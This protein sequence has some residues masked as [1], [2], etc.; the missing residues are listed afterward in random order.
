LYIYPS[1]VSTG[2]TRTESISGGEGVVV[3]ENTKTINVGD[4]TPRRAATAERHME[5]QRRIAEI[6]QLLA[7]DKART[8]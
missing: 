7:A 5:L 4:S 8:K 6:D 1:G 3:I 2:S